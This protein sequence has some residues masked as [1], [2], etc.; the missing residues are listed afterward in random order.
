[1][2]DTGLKIVVP[3]GSPLKTEMFGKKTEFL[4]LDAFKKWLAQYNLE[5]S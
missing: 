5:S 1:M 3:P 4:D 2:Y